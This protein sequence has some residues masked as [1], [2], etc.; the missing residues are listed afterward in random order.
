MMINTNAKQEG[1]DEAA[2]FLLELPGGVCVVDRLTGRKRLG[3]VPQRRAHRR[4]QRPTSPRG[5]RCGVDLLEM[6]DRLRHGVVLRMGDRRQRPHHV[7]AG[8]DLV[9]QELRV[10]EAV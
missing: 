5:N 4:F 2:R 6:V 3:E 1:G 10:R 9:G 7:V 8:A